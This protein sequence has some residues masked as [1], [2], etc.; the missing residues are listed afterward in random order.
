M[1]YWQTGGM[2]ELST[3]SAGRKWIAGLPEALDRQ[4]QILLNLLD[5]CETDSRVA[6]FVVACSVG[7]GAADEYSDLDT[8]MALDVTEADF[9]AAVADVQRAVDRAADL[10]E[11][12]HQKLPGV[13]CTH[14]RIFAQYAN[15]GQ[16]DLV[17]VPVSVDYGGV[18]DE[19]ILYDPDGRRTTKF[20]PQ[21]VT[22]KQVREWAFN[23]WACLADVGKYL[24]RR[25][26]WEALESLHQARNDYLRLL[27]TAVNQ[28]N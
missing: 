6:F 27:A 28:H 15:R 2:S 4:R 26:C 24:H 12:Y 13:N 14:E 11:S 22:P 9:D 5:W 18:K 7:R 19:V 10:V 1:S 3:S 21:P 20:D 17:V 16:V 25:S 8:G 23:A